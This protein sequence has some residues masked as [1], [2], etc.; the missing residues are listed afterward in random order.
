MTDAGRIARAKGLLEL[1]IAPMCR[2]LGHEYQRELRWEGWE[3]ERLF[4]RLDDGRRE[5]L[6]PADW[7]ADYPEA[8]EGYQQALQ[9]RFR[10][11]LRELCTP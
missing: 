4:V 7:L 8:S 10:A 11:K 2:E 5:V 6:I 3:A 9:R 1:T